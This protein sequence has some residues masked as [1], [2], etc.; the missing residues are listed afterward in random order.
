[1]SDFN[2][3]CGLSKKI[4]T[5]IAS[6]KIRGNPSAGSRADTLRIDG[7]DETN[8]RFSRLRRHA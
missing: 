8:S 1:M 5:E 7:Y 3:I 4:S 2:Q 6:I